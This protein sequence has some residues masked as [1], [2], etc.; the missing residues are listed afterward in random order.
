MEP[1]DDG[2]VGSERDVS[3]ETVTPA[4]ARSKERVITEPIAQAIADI[5][6]GDVTETVQ[7]AALAVGVN[8]SGVREALRRYEH[9]E[10]GSEEDER[11]CAILAAGKAAQ[12]K[13]IRQR[14]FD[15]AEGGNSAGVSWMKWQLEVRDPLNNPRHTQQSVELSGP[16]G[17]P[18]QSE[19]VR[20][21]IHVP[22]DEDEE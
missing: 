14:G 4:R 12:M 22:P 21:V 16:G 7:S 9:D 17:G 18:V 1:G 3:S 13:D 8:P 11:V 19:T 6:R 5:M 10:C 2:G 15:S 20:Y